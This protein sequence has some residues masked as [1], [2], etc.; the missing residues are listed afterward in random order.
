MTAAGRPRGAGASRSGRGGSVRSKRR[1][2]ARRAPRPGEKRT[3]SVAGRAGSPPKAGAVRTRTPSARKRVRSTRTASGTGSRRK[4]AARRLGTAPARR[5]RAQEDPGALRARVQE[6]LARLEKLYPD[7]RCSLDHANPL[8]LLVATIL[9]AQC[10]DARVNRVTPELFRRYPTAEDFA[11]ADPAELEER[12]RSTGFFRNKSR[13]IIACCQELVA[14]Y[15]GQVPADLESL[16]QLP[17][18]GRKTANVVLGNAFSIPGI[19]VDTHVTRLSGL[20]SLTGQTDPNKIELDL[21]EVVPRD[22]WTQLAHLFIEHGRRVC[23]AR[24]PRCAECVL[25]DLCPSSEV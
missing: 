16:V 15:G 1:G 9:S 23:I 5:R 18:I 6:I 17:G 13:S 21:M 4:E 8:Q 22:K 3:G 14:R 10:T 20:L 2:G 7:A 24:R 25:N 19:V 12:I 11:G